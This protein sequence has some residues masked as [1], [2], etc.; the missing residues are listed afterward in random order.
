MVRVIYPTFLDTVGAA[1]AIETRGTYSARPRDFN[2]PSQGP[3]KKAASSS[4]SGSSAGSGSSGGSGYDPQS[5]NIGHFKRLLGWRFWRFSLHKNFGFEKI[6]G[7]W[8]YGER[9]VGAHNG[10]AM[11]TKITATGCSVTA[12]VAA[13][14]AVEKTHVLEATAAALSLFGI[15]GEMEMAN[16][17]ATLRIHLIDSLHGPDEACV[18]SRVKITS[19]Y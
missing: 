8:P 18:L 17:P 7:N 16:G 6:V 11:M 4:A 2:C 12:L 5:R 10:F 1:M 15:A 14:V 9:V 19:L 3:S 13:F